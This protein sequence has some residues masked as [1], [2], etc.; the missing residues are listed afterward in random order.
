MLY[1]GGKSVLEW[2]AVDL[3]RIKKRLKELR[4]SINY[5]NYRYYILDQPEISDSEYDLL[6]RELV[7][8]ETNYP[9]FTTP[10][11]PTQRVGAPPLEKFETV[12]HS[13]PMLSLENA[14][15][16]EEAR[17]FDERV[18]RYLKVTGPIEYVIEPKVDGIAI[19]LVYRDG[20][21]T[22]GSTRGD[23]QVG[24]DVTQ[25]LKTI[26]S[27]PLVLIERFE[28]APSRL[29]VR[30]EVYLGI[31]GFKDLNERRMR[32]GLS[33]FAN[34]RNAAAGS[35]RQLDSRITAERP[36]SIFCYG[37]GVVEGRT[38]ETHWEILETLSRWGLRINPHIKCCMGIDQAVEHHTYIAGLRHELSYEMD[39][40]VIKVNSLS[41]QDRL[42]VKT[43]SPRWAVAYKFKSI[44]ATTRILDIRVQVGRTGA[45]TPVAIMEPVMVG[46]VEVSRA[47]LHNPDEIEKKDVRIGDTVLVQRAG[48][49]IPE[50]VMPILS[51]RRGDEKT[52]KMPTS[53][54]VCGEPIE[55]PP[56][57]VVPRCPNPRCLAQ[58]KESIIHFASKGTMD[59]DGM[60]EKLVNQLVERGLLRDYSDIY[61]L[62]FDQLAGLD[63]MAEKSAQNIMTAIE[64]SKETTLGRFLYALGI[65]H[66]GEHMAQVLADNFGSLDALKAAS[67]EDL[68]AVEE[69]GPEVAGSIASF[70]KN[71]K[72]LRIINKILDA[73]VVF[74]K[75][76][77]VRKT[78]LAGRRF[79]FTGTLESFTRDEAKRILQE[80]G[81]LIGSSVSPKT[82]F[83]VAGKDPGSKFQRAKTLNVKIL[84]EDEFRKLIA[85]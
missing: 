7:D 40:T 48:D 29:E 10:D 62:T 39:G 72:N 63:R 75:K 77:V 31:D 78:P 70:F 17:E 54:P 38:F 47:T 23:G 61:Y 15:N 21:F 85:M 41:L 19:E 80:L 45:L 13:I 52:F 20:R 43:R 4:E 37:I 24:E 36:L 58:V 22:V 55:R 82:D 42:G 83:V 30:G 76:R 71:N 59:I 26:K 66:V 11:S 14:F 46:G 34:P 1:Y 69:V 60:G 8:L 44:Q 6:M 9:Q 79:V 32:E 53:C 12:T 2:V 65:R 5:H 64:Y 84:S 3:N 68:M 50:V 81:G 49:V 73:G 33:L 35:L 28:S 18:K 25:N 74:E 51:K 27:I 56:G 67:E 57:E 16:E